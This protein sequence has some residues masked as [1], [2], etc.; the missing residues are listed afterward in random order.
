M[1]IIIM[2]ML[3]DGILTHVMISLKA[4]LF[5]KMNEKNQKWQQTNSIK[6]DR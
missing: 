2:M 5:I 6:V 3:N 4:A 1:E